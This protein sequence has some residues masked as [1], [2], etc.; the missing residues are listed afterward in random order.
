MSATGALRAL[1][2]RSR[3]FGQLD[4]EQFQAFVQVLTRRNP[5]RGEVLFRQG[6]AGDS[7]A[8]VVEGRF[9]VTVDRGAGHIEE[10]GAIVPGDAT[11]EMSCL[12]PAPRSAT[13]TAEED[14]A[15]LLLDRGTLTALRRNAPPIFSSV[16]G[17]I[18][19]LTTARM[20]E[21]R[22][23]VEAAL[24]ELGVA[25]TVPHMEARTQGQGGR[26]TTREERL[27]AA[28]RLKESIGLSE[29]E[30]AHL[31][32]VAQ[33]RS[34]EDGAVVF[35]EG[36]AGEACLVL[37]AGEVELARR[38][39]G[40]ER[41]LAVLGPGA[42]VGQSALVDPGL[43]Q[44]SARARG[45]VY[46]LEFAR[47]NFER[48]L[49]IHAPLALR[50]QEMVATSGIRQLRALNQR[51]VEVQERLLAL[52]HDAEAASARA[53]VREEWEQA[54]AAEKAARQAEQ[55]AMAQPPSVPPFRP[56]RTDPERFHPGR[57]EPT[58]PDLVPDQGVGTPGEAE[59]WLETERASAAVPPRPTNWSAL[60]EALQGMGDGAGDRFFDYAVRKPH[61][62]PGAPG[63]AAR[64]PPV[65]RAATVVMDAELKDTMA[66]VEAALNE[67]ALDPRAVDEVRKKTPPEGA[68]KPGEVKARGNG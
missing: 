25:P 40:R 29:E 50:F 47:H 56:E 52:Q 22:R 51:L 1:F 28:R 59:S 61:A 6:E 35:Q 10:L 27:N 54:Q 32:H 3:L 12:D 45:E 37:L 36:E 9:L 34:F 39:E 2:S 16:I 49:S 65:S 48:L 26:T 64:K 23:R 17:G 4:E 33:E 41:R 13:V 57:E 68:V 7:M 21:T 67:W 14:S 53:R 31:V 18:I 60:Q 42:V 38:V 30:V 20:A 5:R 11:G 8:V 15:V 55:Q 44:S 43:R 66:F 46:A 19:A 62:A 63:A 58:Q 24:G